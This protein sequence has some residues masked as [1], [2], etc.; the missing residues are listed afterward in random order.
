[1]DYVHRDVTYIMT[2]RMRDEQVLALTGARQAGKTTLCEQE[3]PGV[4]GFP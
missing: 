2:V 1:M 3:L 4:T